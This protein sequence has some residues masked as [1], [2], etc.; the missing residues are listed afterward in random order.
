MK[1]EMN[2]TP[3]IAL[4][5]RCDGACGRSEIWLLG[6]LKMMGKG[7]G[8]SGCFRADPGKKF[9]I[10]VHPGNRRRNHSPPF[11]GVLFG[12]EATD[13][14]DCLLVQRGIADD[15]AFG[16]VVAL[17]L[18]LGFDQANHRSVLFQY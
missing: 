15:A 9:L 3:S 1:M 2:A 14:I 10:S 16:N 11:H 12:D 13:F 6:R 8:S 18:K 17:K 5:L 7:R 4:I